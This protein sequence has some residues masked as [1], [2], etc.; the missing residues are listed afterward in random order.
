[1]VAELARHSLGSKGPPLGERLAR[2]LFLK[3]MGD[4]RGKEAPQN[5]S[6]QNAPTLGTPV[7]EAATPLLK[8]QQQCPTPPSLFEAALSALKRKLTV[9]MSVKESLK[10]NN[11]SAPS[12]YRPTC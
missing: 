3:E 8:Q 2:G 12:K 7:M 5:F 11:E 1:M 4:L 6:C 10:L 9:E